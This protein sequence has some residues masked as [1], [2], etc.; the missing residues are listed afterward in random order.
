MRRFLALSVVGCFLIGSATAQ[1]V[2]TPLSS[3]PAQK[4]RMQGRVQTTLD[5]VQLPFIDDFSNSS[6]VPSARRW[7]DRFVFVNT[8]M[9]DGPPTLGIAT[10]DGLNEQGEAYDPL[11]VNSNGLADR[12]TS[13][14]INLGLETPADSVY[15]SFLFQP[16]GLCDPPESN[17]SLTLEWFTR[18]GVWQSVWSQTGGANR[19]F[20]QVHLPVTDTAF[21]HPGFRMRWSSYGNLSGNVDVWH[22]DYVRLNRNRNASDTLITD[23][24]FRLRPSPLV[25]PYQEMPWRQYAADSL[26]FKAL[27][28]VSTARNLGGP[29]NVAYKY[30]ARNMNNGTTIIDVGEQNISPFPSLS[31]LPFS[32]QAFPIPKPESGDSL[33]LET[34][35]SLRTAPDFLAANDTV[36]R[37]HRFWNHFAYD[38][39]TA[40]TGYGLNTIGGSVAY[41]FYV[42]RPD[43]LRGMWMQ[44]TQAANNAS[45]E[46]FNLKVW[47]FIGE[48]SFTGNE[49]V[50]TQQQLQRPR[51][52]DSIGQYVYYALDTPVVVRDSF[53]VGWQ[54]LTQRLLNIGLDRNNNVPGTKWFNVQ[55]QWNPSLI[56]GTWMIRPVI[57]DSLRYPTYVAAQKAPEVKVYPNP[58][59]D[60]LFVQTSKAWQRYEVLDLQGRTL[61]QGSFIDGQE[62]GIVTSWLQPGLYLLR[63]HWGDGQWHT[64][65]FVRQ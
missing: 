44:F 54:Q 7:T 42:A 32:F 25:Q 51:Y 40:E 34:T 46:L 23:V 3:N 48:G 10:F 30:S 36:R 15:L 28:H 22:L 64:T 37:V 6:V 52:A 62:E 35:Y 57:G 50:L 59:T 16:A 38:D 53:Y 21:L 24:G 29:R 55:G 60:I 27:N 20:E 19:P 14:A 41:K 31:D 61:K 39:G 4:H 18:S 8:D 26:R 58:V 47:A 12:L 9:A 49:S 1:E 5:T 56:N 33:T 2:V 63:L 45:L 13:Q 17:D 65:R 43:T 11:S